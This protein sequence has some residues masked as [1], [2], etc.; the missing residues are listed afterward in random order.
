MFF[1]KNLVESRIFV[2]NAI[3]QKNFR[4]INSLVTSLVTTLISRKNRDRG[5]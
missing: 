1:I 5:L 3:T 2:Q 4:E